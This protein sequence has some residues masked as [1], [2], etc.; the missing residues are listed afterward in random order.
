MIET[1][2]GEPFTA[3]L[4]FRSHTPRIFAEPSIAARTKKVE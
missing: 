4:A 1:D 3:R 2:A